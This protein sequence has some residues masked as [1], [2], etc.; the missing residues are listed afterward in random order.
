MGGDG[1][2]RVSEVWGHNHL[3]TTGT[4]DPTLIITWAPARVIIK[5]SGH[6]HWW[7]AGGYDLEKGHFQKWLAWW[8]LGFIVFFCGG[9]VGGVF[10]FFLSV[11]ARAYVSLLHHMIDSRS[12]F[13]VFVSVFVSGLC[14]LT[15]FAQST[16]NSMQMRCKLQLVVLLE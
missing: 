4:D 10:L 15:L 6:R 8:L 5:V 12:L 1:G 2:C 13:F 9:W 14:H 7:L 3:L 11:S 16:T